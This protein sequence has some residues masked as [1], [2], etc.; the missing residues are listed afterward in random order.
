MKIIVGIVL[1]L[2]TSPIIFGQEWRDS[3][4]E[5][6]K[7][8]TQK[9]YEQ[10]FRVYR[11]A[12]KLAP[13][14]IDL[15]D[16]VGQS[17]YKAGK[18]EEAENI[19]GQSS[20]MKGSANQKGV[21]YRQIGN[22]R[23]KQQKYAEAVESYKESLRNNPNDEDARY[24][25]AE[26]NRKLNQQKEQQKKQDQQD[27]KNQ[28]DKNQDPSNPK[29]SNPKNSDQQDQPKY[30][31]QQKE[32]PN[33]QNGGK[34]GQKEQ[35]KLEDQGKSKLKQSPGQKKTQLSDKKTERML[36]ELMRKEM[37]TKRK[38]EGIKSGEGFKKSGKDW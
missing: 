1:L 11:S 22:A 9:N 16:E 38:F 6:R 19:Y 34:P 13:K 18:Y 28:K 7:L 4:R 32:Q 21:N 30:S 10:S 23:M 29:K 17:A 36:D 14:E 20:S 12:Q 3:L 37:E 5:A 27:G 33:Q 15:S 25:L 2:V 31:G 8:Y 26:A 35:G 24:N